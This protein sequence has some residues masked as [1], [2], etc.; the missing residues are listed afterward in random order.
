MRA[1]LFC[2]AAAAALLTGSGLAVQAKPAD[3]YLS[4]IGGTESQMMQPY[5]VSVRDENGNRIIINGRPVVSDGS[6]LRSAGPM[7]FGGQRSAGSTLS[8]ST[9]GAVAIG[10]SVSITDAR[11]SFIVI[12]QTNTGSVTANSGGTRSEAGGGQ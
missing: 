4:P 9:L 5:T 8:G 3:P 2:A 1:E 6:T 10:N 11:N 12:N 7:T